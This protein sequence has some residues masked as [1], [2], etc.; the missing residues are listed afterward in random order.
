MPKTID[1]IKLVETVAS[2]Y[3]T[4][5]DS[6]NEVL[7]N[8]NGIQSRDGIAAIAQLQGL[9][10]EEL[11]NYLVRNNPLVF[12]ECKR[13][14]TETNAQGAQIFYLEGVEYVSRLYESHVWIEEETV[15][16]PEV[17]VLL[18]DPFAIVPPHMR[19]SSTSEEIPEEQ[20]AS[21]RGA[22][23]TEIVKLIHDNIAVL[24]NAETLESLIEY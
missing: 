18:G 12:V 14:I 1:K 7:L 11:G 2:I 17:G 15:W 19:H 3:Y 24:G 6:K 9:S 21:F 5:N 10:A 23:L 8:F 16:P 22:I 20:K 4:E 13:Y